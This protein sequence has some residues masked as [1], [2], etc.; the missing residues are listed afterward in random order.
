MPLL[1]CAI[2]V[3]II[4]PPIRRLLFPPAPLALHS[5]TSGEV[6][7]PQAGYLGSGDSLTGAAE[8]YKGLAAE[9]EATNFVSGLT[10]IAVGSVSGQ[11]APSTSESVAS[12][13][14]DAQDSPSKAAGE[15]GRALPDPTSVVSGAATA[16]ATASGE[17]LE[18]DK[19]KKPME[20]AMWEA[21]G[22]FMHTLNITADLWERLAK[23]V[24]IGVYPID[25]YA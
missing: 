11:G 5:P 15:I 22:P 14:P 10:S 23:S 16:Q 6:Q 25:N 4:Y 17:P 20:D 2:I 24:P 9:Q 3:L 13:P 8:A 12:E 19:T 7:T 18:R 1:F 21:A